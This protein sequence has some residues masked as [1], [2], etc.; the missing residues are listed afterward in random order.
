MAG[1]FSIEAIFKLKDRMTRPVGKIQKRMDRMTRRARAGLASMNKGFS[2]VNKGIRRMGLAVGAAAVGIGLAFKSIVGTG[3]EFEQAITNVGA[4]SL[5]SRKEIADLEKQA[6]ELGASTKFTATEVASGMEIMAKAGFT[7]AETMSGIQGVLDAAAASGLE[8]AEVANVVSNALKGMGLDTSEAARV[9]DVLALASSRTNSTIGTLGESL[10]NVASTA[11]QLGI[12]LED[13][14]AAVALLQDVG[15]DASVAGSALNTMLTKLAKPPKK[16]ARQMKKLGITF[17]DAKGDMLPFQDVL[18]GIDKASKAAGGSFDKVAFL[19]D[20][21]GLRGQKAAANLTDLFAS[22]KLQTLTKELESAEGA[23]KKMAD[24]RMDTFQ[25]DVLKLEAAVDG[26]KIAMFGV[27]SPLREIVQGMTE[28]V[29]ANKDL[30]VAELAGFVKFLRENFWDIVAGLK[31]IG[32]TLAVFWSLQAAINAARIAMSLY[33]GAT[34]VAKG[35]MRLFNVETAIADKG[36]RGLIP[37]LNASKMGGAINGI[38]GKMG[39]AGLLGAVFA[40]TLGLTTLLLKWTGLDKKLDRFGKFLAGPK[41]GEI[42]VSKVRGFGGQKKPKAPDIS[43]E[44]AQEAAARASAG[45]KAAALASLPPGARAEAV[46]R[47][48]AATKAEVVTPQERTA[49]EITETTT[50]NNDNLDI[51]VRAPDGTAEVTRKPNRAGVTLQDS[52]G[53]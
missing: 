15:L 39:K 38:K 46:A 42:G 14:V 40:V 35:A 28:W 53:L 36:L 10:K 8:M 11:R 5:K 25:G 50:T 49:R 24:I 7:T 12:P 44:F 22:G 19:A 21:V 32:V 33:A 37:A 43:P 41:G 9:A 1:R 45:R 23:A 48:N 34:I 26:V 16:L 51:T 18:Q 52:G 20:L 27:D 17:K 29:G 4:V 3:A 30:I 31:A 6:L 2:R 47:A 13:T